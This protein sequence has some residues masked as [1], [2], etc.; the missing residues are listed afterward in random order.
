GEQAMRD[1]PVGQPFDLAIG[2]AMDVR[3]RPRLVAEQDRGRDR[4]R[5]VYEVDLANA[6]TVPIVVEVRT[7]TDRQG[8][9]IVAE[10]VAHDIRDGAAAWRLS[11]P[12]NGR[13][14]V[15]LVVEYDD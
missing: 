5:K 8:F 2:E 4:V 6:K 11:V 15:R 12:A 7:S 1:V 13:K 9:K 10:P 3:I 14:T